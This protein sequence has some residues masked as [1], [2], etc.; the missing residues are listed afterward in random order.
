MHSEG[1]LQWCG[2][3]TYCQIRRE[4]EFH[5]RNHGMISQAFICIPLC[6]WRTRNMNFRSQFIICMDEAYIYF[7]FQWCICISDSNACVEPRNW[8]VSL[9]HLIKELDTVNLVHLA[10][11]KEPNYFW[12]DHLCGLWSLRIPACDRRVLC[13]ACG[14]PCH[15][16]LCCYWL[17]VLCAEAEAVRNEYNEADTK[18]RDAENEVK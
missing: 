18:V 10:D 8:R 3:Q 2:E 15:S 1:K 13:G 7:Q 14:Q 11:D 9:V 16:A 12:Y 4:Q 6:E 5:D 17:W